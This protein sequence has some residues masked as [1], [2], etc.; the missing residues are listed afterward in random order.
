[1]ARDIEDQLVDQSSYRCPVFPLAPLVL[2]VREHDPS[3][4]FKSI[5]L[6]AD[7][8]NL[9]KLLRWTS[10][11]TSD[12]RLD[13]EVAGGTVLLT[14]WEEKA[15]EVA[16]AGYGHRFEVEMTRNALVGPMGR[17]QLRGH[18]RIVSFV[19]FSSLLRQLD[20]S[21]TSALRRSSTGDRKSVV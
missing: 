19:R 14:R 16:G 5:E 1:M 11:G 10:G 9:R 8:N 17:Q 13:V 20:S 2:A 12:F 15:V 7:R 3:F 18:N 21:L 6:V 4:D